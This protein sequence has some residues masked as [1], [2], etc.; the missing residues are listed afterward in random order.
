MQTSE[1][2][3][4]LSE[5]FCKLQ[6]KLSAIGKDVQ[7]YKYKYADLPAVWDSFRPFLL[8]CG[9]SV[10]QDV[11]TEE[12]GVR[13]STRIQ[14]ISGQ[15]IQ[16]GYLHIPMEKKDAHSTGSAVTYGRR[17]SLCAILGIVTC[18][19]DDDGKKAMGDSK[20]KKDTSNEK[21]DERQVQEIE[22]FLDGHDDI[23]VKLYTWAGIRLL[24]D[25]TVDNF[26]SALK[27]VKAGT[28]GKG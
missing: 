22:S 14:H 21:I 15:F 28:N 10:I 4:K 12:D 3:D 8:E 26:P 9:L 20:K 1:E 6:S 5:S 16:T 18:D 23:R 25:L 7:A 19:E 11:K 27:S 2:I 13:V 17:Y 24:A